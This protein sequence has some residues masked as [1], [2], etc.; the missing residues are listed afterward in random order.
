A[1]VDVQDSSSTSGLKRDRIAQ[2]RLNVDNLTKQL[3]K[4]C[5]E[6]RAEISKIAV[7]RPA[8]REK[9]SFREVKLQGLLAESV[10]V[11]RRSKSLTDIIA[12]METD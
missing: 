6:L 4:D 1:E 9:K 3:D 2:I 5:L 8:E 7:L 12:A 11:L 10:N